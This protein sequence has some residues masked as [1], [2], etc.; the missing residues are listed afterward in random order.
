M[1]K[2]KYRYWGKERYGDG[3]Y[4]GPYL[5]VPYQD[6]SGP[7]L[8]CC[9]TYSDVSAVF[10]TNGNKVMVLLKSGA[11]FCVPISYNSFMDGPLRLLTL[12]DNRNATLVDYGPLSGEQEGE[13]ETV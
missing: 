7:I 4:V 5:E 10:E 3:S 8:T 12:H 13:N 11:K 1:T 9:L 2:Q 6:G